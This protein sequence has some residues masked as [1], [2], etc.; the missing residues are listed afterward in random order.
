MMFGIANRHA[1]RRERKLFGMYPYVLLHWRGCKGVAFYYKG[2]PDGDK[3]KAEDIKYANGRI[4]KDGELCVCSSCGYAITPE[5][6][7]P[8]AFERVH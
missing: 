4:P 8:E 5:E 7:A 3:L 2:N 1:K 6:L